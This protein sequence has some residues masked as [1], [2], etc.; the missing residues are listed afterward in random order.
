M[1]SV[2]ACMIVKNEA[3]NVRPCLESLGDLPS[4][5]VIVDTGSSDDTARIARSMGAQ[6]HHFQW[7]GDFAAAR[8]ESLRHATEDWIFWL[9]AD[10]RLSPETVG[11]LKQAIRSGLADAYICPVTSRLS[12][13]SQGVTEHVRLF[14]NGL[15][16]T[17]RGA[18]HESVLP[19]LQRMGLRSARID[20]IIEHTGYESPEALRRKSRRNLEM[21]EAE[22]SHDRQQVDMIFYRGQSRLHIEDLQGCEADMQD[23]LRLT[24]PSASFDWKRLS[25]YMALVRSLERQSRSEE[26]EPFLLAALREFPQHPTFLVMLGRLYLTQGKPQTALPMLLTAHEACQATVRGHHPPLAAV[27]VGLARCYHAL[28]A[29]AEALYWAERASEHSSTSDSA[30][31]VTARFLLEAGDLAR[32]EHLLSAVAAANPTAESL[33][34]ESEL[35]MRSGRFQEARLALQ[36]AKDKGLAGHQIEGLLRRVE[37]VSRLAASRTCTPSSSTEADRQLQGLVSLAEGRHLQAA[38]LF[39]GI[40]QLTP[41]N[42]DNYRYLAVALRAMGKE[43]EAL[44]AW[45]LA[46]LAAQHEASRS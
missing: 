42:P 16:I 4:E 20:A 28:G 18:I 2:S 21:I 7:V 39:A 36:Q 3:A 37:A 38:E 13:A 10:D 22:L 31:L 35:R 19:D 27:E 6:I 1:P 23:F 24:P 40:I 25:A 14:R 30:N 17:F 33:V 34:I 41:A 11:Q 15:G 45:Q 43:D 26:I 32:A 46:D 12:D 9:D 44:K 5:I 8:N 29:K